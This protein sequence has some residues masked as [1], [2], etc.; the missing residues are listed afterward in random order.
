[1]CI[2]FYVG[3]GDCPGLQPLTVEDQTGEDKEGGIPGF[4]VG[5]VAQPG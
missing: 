2:L 4:S 3:T 1:M 5:I